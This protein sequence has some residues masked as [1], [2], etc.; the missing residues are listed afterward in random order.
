M[1]LLEGSYTVDVD[2]DPLMVEVI[3][4]IHSSSYSLTQL[5]C[6]H[7]HSSSI[8]SASVHVF[9]HP[10]INLFHPSTQP[11]VNL[12]PCIHSLIIIHPFIHSSMDSPNHPF[13]HS[14]THQPICTPIRLSV[15]IHPITHLLPSLFTYKSIYTFILHAQPTYLPSHPSVYS[16]HPYNR[17]SFKK[18]FSKHLTNLWAW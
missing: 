11:P 3:L 5:P 1:I 12:H 9:F 6:T 10:L 16:Y 8:Q 18:S 13:T 2:I 15:P 17:P 7:L 4:Y 14:C